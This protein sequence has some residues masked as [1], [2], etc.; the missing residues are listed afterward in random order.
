M[1]D[2]PTLPIYLVCYL[3]FIR[4]EIAAAEPRFAGCLRSSADSW[5]KAIC[6]VVEPAA[7][8]DTAV[9]V[10]L[11]DVE[12]FASALERDQ[13]SAAEIELAQRVARVALD[14]LH[15]QLAAVR[16]SKHAFYRGW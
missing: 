13:P 3:D 7:E 4:E 9:A 1:I 10:A 12:R 2:L 16:P 8:V 14:Q 6:R 15:E 11:E 5:L